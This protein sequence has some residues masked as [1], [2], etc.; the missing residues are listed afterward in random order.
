MVSGCSVEENGALP[1]GEPEFRAE[2]ALPSSMASTNASLQTTASNG[3][4]FVPARLLEV[5]NDYAARY[6]GIAP[7]AAPLGVTYLKDA[8]GNVTA[9]SVTY[10]LGS[11]SH[12]TAS[13]LQTWLTTQSNA[14]QTAIDANGALP[15]GAIA[16]LRVSNDYLNVV[17]GA[18]PRQ[19]RLLSMSPGLP[20]QAY[21]QLGRRRIADE[22]DVPLASVSA[23]TA[24][25]E[26]SLDPSTR[27]GL[28]YQVTGRGQHLY[29]VPTGGRPLGFVLSAATFTPARTTAITNYKNALVASLGQPSSTPLATL[30]ETKHAQQWGRTFALMDAQHGAARVAAC[31][32]CT[33]FSMNLYES[34][35]RDFFNQVF[36]DTNDECDC[37]ETYHDGHTRVVNDCDN[38]SE[39]CCELENGE[40]PDTT[41]VEEC[42]LDCECECEAQEWDTVY[43]DHLLRGVPNLYQQSVDIPNVPWCHDR[44]G[45]GCGPVATAELAIW[46][47]NLGYDELLDHHHDTNGLFLWQDLTAELR[48]DFIDVTCWGGATYATNENLAEGTFDFFFDRGVPAGVVHDTVEV[49]EE[50][51]AWNTIRD[52]IEL[53]RPLILGFNS[54]SVPL[55]QGSMDHFALI[56]GHS[57]TIGTKEIHLNMGW[58]LGSHEVREW[59]LVGQVHLITVDV[60]TSP[61]GNEECM[62]D[63]PLSSLFTPS[64]NL[65]WSASSWTYDDYPVVEHLTGSADPDCD[66]IGGVTNGWF[67]THWT[68]RTACLTPHDFEVLDQ[69]YQEFQEELDAGD[70]PDWIWE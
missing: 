59:D 58:G 6:E 33:S 16:G 44:V 18:T 64:S 5:A 45:V 2:A 50:S 23:G 19:P 7:D 68:E 27:M 3:H 40:Y 53:N 62:A 14:I 55:G 12:P 47:D 61:T 54:D 46:Y 24:F 56:T 39:R 67:D 25:L 13:S 26:S 41:D 1:E 15:L 52:E 57:T 66:R 30:L 4:A 20:V 38:L 60:S 43:Y 21:E 70:I 17:V 63:T 9:M 32:N 29:F 69:Q 8:D 11:L 51:S 35:V 49:S 37:I 22:L 10:A 65:D 28:R 34:G 48:E 42:L 36:V 31:T